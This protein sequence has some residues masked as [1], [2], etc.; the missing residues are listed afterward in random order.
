[1]GIAL[2]DLDNT[3]ID[4]DSDYQWGNF[5]AGKGIVSKEE[6]ERKN[7]EFYEQYYR[8]ELDVKKYINF[9]YKPLADNNLEK[10]IELRDE[11][12]NKEIK[13]LIFSEAEKIISNHISVGDTVAIVTSTNSFVSK[14]VADY[15][16][17]VHLIASEPEFTNGKFTGNISGEPCYQHGKVKKVEFWMLENKID[18]EILSNSTYFYTDSYNDISL[19]NI[20]SDPVAVNPDKNLESIAKDNKWKVLKFR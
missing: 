5:L 11:F 13:N 14:P 15:L 20:V 4:G 1:M 18:R 3:I 2:F 19:L 16:N 6:Y 10:L 7:K 12:F 9:S 8:G 17:I